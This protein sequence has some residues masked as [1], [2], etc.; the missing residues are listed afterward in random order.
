MQCYISPN[1]MKK[2]T[3]LHFGWPEDEYIFSKYL[4]FGELYRYALIPKPSTPKMCTFTEVHEEEEKM[5]LYFNCREI[6]QWT[7]LKS[8]VAFEFLLAKSSY[9][10][11][12]RHNQF[13]AS[14]AILEMVLTAEHK[15]QGVRLDLD[16]TPP[17][18]NTPKPTHLHPLDVDPTPPPGSMFCSE[19]LL[20]FWVIFTSWKQLGFKE[21]LLSL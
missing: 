20:Q 6:E 14:Y 2:Q 7:R 3:D 21:T 9:F 17:T 5:T 10:N 8:A 1:L 16:P 11:K 15:I 19:G 12:N 18:L 13:H 4:F